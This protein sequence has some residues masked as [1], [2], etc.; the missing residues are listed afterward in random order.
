MYGSY[1][2]K[3]VE[4]CIGPTDIKEKYTI[5]KTKNWLAGEKA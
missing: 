2:G 5:I 4:P 1:S 3:Q